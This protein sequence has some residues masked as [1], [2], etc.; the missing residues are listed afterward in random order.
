MSK[1]GKKSDVYKQLLKELSEKTTELEQCQATLKTINETYGDVINI[2]KTFDGANILKGYLNNVYNVNLRS[3]IP[4][5]QYTFTMPSEKIKNPTLYMDHILFHFMRQDISSLVTILNYELTNNPYDLK[6]SY[7][8]SA[9]HAGNL[10][11]HKRSLAWFINLKIP[12]TYKDSDSVIRN[13]K[14]IFKI[15]QNKQLVD[16]RR[17]HLFYDE[18]FRQPDSLFKGQLKTLFTTL[19][20]EFL[21]GIESRVIYVK[22]L[23]DFKNT[24]FVED[25]KS[26]D[27]PFFMLDFAL[28]YSF[29]GENTERA[30]PAGELIN[31]LRGTTHVLCSDFVAEIPDFNKLFN[32]MNG[33]LNQDEI[34]LMIKRYESDKVYDF[35]NPYI[36]SIFKNYFLS[37]WHKDKYELFLTDLITQHKANC[38]CVDRNNCNFKELETILNTLRDDIAIFDFLD[39]WTLCKEN[40]DM[41][42]AIDFDM[43]TPRYFEGNDLINGLR[44]DFS[45]KMLSE[46]ITNFEFS[47]DK[48]KTWLDLDRILTNFQLRKI[49]RFLQ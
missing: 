40:M 42:N 35:T 27:N 6:S 18:F 47:P 37:F 41:E 11:N 26:L 14:S 28:Y 32:K 49:K 38:N 34:E 8:R 1:N 10:E 20:L 23:D 33:T 15:F 3:K 30:E 48:T 39:F 22:N 7:K 25:K 13:Q 12:T 4:I 2:I 31:H 21:H 19:L 24:V 43:F 5:N 9:Q 45:H 16:A 46:I 29:K 44:K 36:Y 17:M